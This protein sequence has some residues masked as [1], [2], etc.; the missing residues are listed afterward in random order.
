MQ[1]AVSND[2]ACPIVISNIY[3][4]LECSGKFVLTLLRGTLLLFYSCNLEAVGC[5]H[6]VNA[7]PFYKFLDNVG[8][9]LIRFNVKGTLPVY[10]LHTECCSNLHREEATVNIYI[11]S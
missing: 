8:H 4:L 1:Q 5:G 7:A 6:Y 11:F 3:A 2:T 9:S 10:A